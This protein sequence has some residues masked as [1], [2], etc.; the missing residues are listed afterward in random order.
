MENIS[1]F[2]IKKLTATFLKKEEVEVTFLTPVSEKEAIKAIEL[3]EKS[4]LVNEINAVKEK[5]NFQDRA[6]I[7]E[8][9]KIGWRPDDGVEGFSKEVELPQLKVKAMLG[10]SCDDKKLRATIYRS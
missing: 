1:R 2:F 6:S 4:Q 10:I 5:C 3:L 8:L 9:G 7:Y